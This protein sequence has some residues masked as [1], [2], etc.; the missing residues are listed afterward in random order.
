[1]TDM[2]VASPDLEVG[3]PRYWLDRLDRQL[4]ERRPVLARYAAYYDGDHPL[5]FAT[6]K[7]RQAFG[8]QFRD[9]A[10]NWCEMV[11]DAVEDRLNIRGFRLGDDPAA[12]AP[13]WSIWQRNQMD[14]DAQLAHTESLIYGISYAGVWPDRDGPAIT[15]ESPL[16]VTVAKQAGSRR[17]RAAALKVWREDDGHDL[18]TLYLPN[19]LYK[20]RTHTKGGDGTAGLARWEPRE[21]DG[22]A[23]PLPNPFG[24]VPVVPIENKPRLLVAGVSEIAKVIPVQDAINKT[25]AD[26]LVAAEFNGMRQRWATGMEIPRDPETN[27]PIEPFGTAIKRLWIAED[28][29]TTFGEFGETNLR[30]FV[31]TVAMFVQHIAS[32]TRTPPHYL[33]PGADRLSGESIKAAET[34]LVAKCRRKMVFFGEAWEE[35]IRLA[36]VAAGDERRFDASQAETIWGDPES[37]TESEHVDAVMKQQALGVP[38][39]VLWEKLGYSPQ[40]IERIKTIRRLEVLE[41]AAAAGDFGALFGTDTTVK[42]PA[43]GV[44]R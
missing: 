20:F 19:A 15:V 30:G 39:E 44:A 43:V 29:N 40:E 7:F 41:Q 6:E 12:D 9:F 36:L 27:Q 22:E 38:N 26:M 4:A 28:E 33:N 32:Q 31:E 23:W 34:G 37:R 18:A 17:E 21:I 10:D 13:A 24:V 25:I 5:E 42:P 35:I 3:S 2:A 1:M 11:V 8:H 16:Q 14:A